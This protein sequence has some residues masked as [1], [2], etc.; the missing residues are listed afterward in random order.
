MNRR[1]FIGALAA[2]FAAVS[3]P[4]P[5]AARLLARHEERRRAALSLESFDAILKA[6][7]P[8]TKIAALADMPRTPLLI[9]A[10]VARDGEV[11]RV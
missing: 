1:G 10:Y 2:G 4:R 7:Y 5:V 6:H 8:Q 3:M 9:V 11:M